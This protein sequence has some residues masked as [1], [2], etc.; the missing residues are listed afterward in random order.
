MRFFGFPFWGN[1]V[2]FHDVGYRHC[3]R[4]SSKT[5]GSSSN[6][7]ILIVF[8]STFVVLFP[9]FEPPE[10]LRCRHLRLDTDI[11]SV[12]KRRKV[13]SDWID[14]HLCA[15]CKSR[16]NDGPRYASLRIENTSN[17]SPLMRLSWTICFCNTS[18]RHSSDSRSGKSLNLPATSRLS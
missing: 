4:V 10:Y 8:I 16:L 2:S 14:N 1:S 6:R 5:D 13:F 9:E 17:A 7:H 18:L 15:M 12:F 11:A 3:L